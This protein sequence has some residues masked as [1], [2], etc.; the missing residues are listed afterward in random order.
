MLQPM[1]IHF[2]KFLVDYAVELCYGYHC[3]AKQQIL[4]IQML[5]EEFQIRQI[6]DVFGINE[7]TNQSVNTYATNKQTWINQ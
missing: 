6:C 1:L 5:S 3:Y 2:T 7:Q 4:H